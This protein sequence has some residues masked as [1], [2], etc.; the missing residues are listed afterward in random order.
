M[1]Y[2]RSFFLLLFMVCGLNIHAFTIRRTFEVTNPDTKLSPYTGMNREHW[3]QAAEYL[4]NTAFQYINDVKDPFNLPKQP[5]K[6][7]PHNEGGVPTARMEA[8]CRTMFLAGPLLKENPGLTLHGIKV[9]DYYRYQIASFLSPDS[10]IFL[11]EKRGGGNGGQKLVELGGLAV[12]L[13]MAPEVFWHRSRRK[14]VTVLP[15]CLRL[16][17]RGRRLT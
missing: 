10:P 6:T 8:L 9:G 4:L 14:P 13:L 7:Y 16:M 3:K 17:P 2:S 1:N 11:P 15:L 5:G 12:S